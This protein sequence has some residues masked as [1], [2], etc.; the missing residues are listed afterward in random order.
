MQTSFYPIITKP[1]RV[2]E[3]TAT[4]IDHIY[5]NSVDVEISSG[6]LTIDIS[7]HLPVFCV[8]QN[9]LVKEDEQVTY[10]RDFSKFNK[11]N[12][13]HDLEGIDWRACVDEDLNIST[14]K[15]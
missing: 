1:T 10:F 6:I 15:N 3:H 8:L 13:L 2:T 12:Y 9:N 14:T 4:L 11:K 7:D 5:T